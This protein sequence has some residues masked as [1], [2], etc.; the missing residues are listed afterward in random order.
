MKSGDLKRHLSPYSI[1]G[2]RRT[3]INH[4][5]ASALAPCD[6]YDPERVS[7]AISLLGQEADSDLT[8]VY[9]GNNAETWDHLVGL[10]R[11]SELNGFGHQIGNLVPCCKECN[12]R[13]GNRD[14]R[15]FL[16]E[17]N[18]DDAD[19]MVREQR[20]V[21]YLSAF[22]TAIDLTKAQ[23][24]DVEWQR[25]NEIRHEILRLMREADQLAATLQF[26]LGNKVNPD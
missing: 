5:F 15:K 1:H 24:R 4:A 23:D 21:S 11:N 10:V 7:R 18:T 20:I 22:A 3:T 9:C 8:C 26:V 17:R 25:Y 16:R 14:W 12:S 6:V 13:K 2:S 19:F